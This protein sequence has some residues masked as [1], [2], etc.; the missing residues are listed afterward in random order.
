MAEISESQAE[1]GIVDSLY[2]ISSLVSETDD[3]R[4]AL[5]VVVDELVNA[6]DAS[7][8]SVALIDPD[9]HELEIEVHRG[10]QLEQAAVRLPLGVGVT[11]QVALSGKPMLVRDVA[12]E[13]AYVALKPSIRS[14]IAAP[15]VVRS[16]ASGEIKESVVGVVNVDSEQ[17]GAFSERDLKLLT[18]LTNEATRVVARLW[19][20]RQQREKSVQLETVL[21]AGARLVRQHDPRRILS[22]IARD[23]VRLVSCRLCAIF[24][25]SPDG[26]SLRLECVSDPDRFEVE[27]AELRPDDSAV[28]VA[29]RRRKQVSVFNLAKSEEHH[30]VDLVQT[31]GLQ[32]ML[33][34][35][36][37]YESDVIGLLNVYTGLPHRFSNDERR[38]LES[39]ASMGAVAI[40][41][42]R[43]Y[44]RVFESEES[45]RKNDR[46]TTLGMLAAEIAHEI[47]NPLTVIKLL[48]EALDLDYGGN[49]PRS[50]DAKVI[51]E[52]IN[53]L[54]EIVGRVLE[55]GRSRTGL[56]ARYDLCELIRETIRLVRLKLDQSKVRIVFEDT[57]HPVPVK[58]HKGQI[59]QVLINL[60]FN[61]LQAMS[62]GGEISILVDV[63]R[64][65]HQ[66]MAE[67][68]VYDTGNGVP[69]TIRD[70]IFDSFLTGRADGSGLGLAISKRIIKAHHGNLDLVDSSEDGTHFRFTLPMER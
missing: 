46:L 10:L 30:L 18:V 23:A 39:L 13:P 61:S 1:H 34:T 14:E 67:L 5:E 12:Q 58:V 65:G 60:I 53:Q 19:H 26:K 33:A 8:V 24:L 59:Q 35:P 21:N 3:V 31:E 22:L 56:H 41:N 16:L 57:P 62:D 52:K 69:E 40:Q 44:E 27:K 45:M 6:L 32:S 17:V 68:N 70:R 37:V 4:H 47:R 51:R 7:S 55:F 15:M 11:G 28:G 54:E 29:I 25:L 64:V 63:I 50:Q 36:I 2:R 66:R 49:D 38:L 48:F 42:A 20:I 43:L 9:T